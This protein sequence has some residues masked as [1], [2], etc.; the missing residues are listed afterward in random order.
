MASVRDIRFG[1]V[2]ITPRDFP[3]Y[4]PQS[5]SVI[6]KEC[7]AHEYKTLIL[8]DMNARIPD[9]DN[10]DKPNSGISYHRNVDTR[11]NANGRELTL[12]MDSCR[13]NPLNHMRM[14]GKQFGGGFTFKQKS[15]WISQ[16]DWA[17]CS[18]DILCDVISFNVMQNDVLPTNHAPI[19]LTLACDNVSHSD[20]LTRA[21]DLG[22]SILP[23]QPSQQAAVSMTRIDHASFQSNLPD[24]AD[25]WQSTMSTDQM[26]SYMSNQLID[27]AVKSQVPRTHCN[28]RKVTN[29]DD[30]WNHIIRNKDPRQLWQS[31]NWRG[32]F[33]TAPD[34]L[35]TPPDS[36][37]CEYFRGIAQS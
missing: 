15:Q 23:K 10:F 26:A 20:L 16:L 21:T 6:Q 35:E 13:L 37:F 2:Y 34:R 8:G 32:T 29:A 31:I 36:D 18:L 28:T 9:L 24:P 25:F 22:Q 30:R 12:I 27:T 7:I 14:D 1:A 4:S 17:L 11:G 3:F 33:D 19:T 5:F